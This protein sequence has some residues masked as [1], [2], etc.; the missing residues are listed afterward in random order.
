ML[1]LLKEAFQTQAINIIALSLGENVSGMLESKLFVDGK[2]SGRALYAILLSGDNFT[3]WFKIR[4]KRYRM[5]EGIHFTQKRITIF[6]KTNKTPIDYLL[7]PT[8][9]QKIANEYDFQIPL[10]QNYAFKPVEEQQ[11][12]I[13]NIAKRIRTIKL[14]LEDADEEVC[15]ILGGVKMQLV[16]QK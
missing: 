13:Q 12:E 3:P 4:I 5:K 7:D 16:F 14:D 6:A 10:P 9:A 15:I 2:I 8:V 11:P 1:N